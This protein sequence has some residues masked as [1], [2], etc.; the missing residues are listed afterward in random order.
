LGVAGWKTTEHE[1]DWHIWWTD[2]SVGEERCMRLRRPQ[3]LNHFPGMSE[4]A[5]KCKLARNLN[6]LRSVLP[7]LYNFH[8]E[9]FNLPVDYLAFENAALGDMEQRKGKGGKSNKS[10]IIKPDEGACGVGIFITRKPAEVPPKLACVAQRYLNKPLLIDDRKFDMRL[11]VLITSMTP[12][13]VYLFPEGLARFATE[14]FQPVTSANMNQRYM[15]L[16]NYSVNR[17]HKDFET[18]DSADAATGSKRS[19]TFVR[20]WLA[21]KGFD[22]KGIWTEIEKVIVKTLLAVQ[23]YVSHTYRTC[24]SSN[25]DCVGFSCFDLLGFDILLD[26]KAKPWIIEVNEMPSFETAAA[27]DLSTKAA[28]LHETLRLVCPTVQELRMLTEMTK[29]VK[30]A[31]EAKTAERRK[32]QALTPPPGGCGTGGGHS[33]QEQASRSAASDLSVENEIRQ[34]LLNLRVQQEK[35]QRTRFRLLY[36]LADPEEDGRCGGDEWCATADAL[37]KRY[38]EEPDD[39]ELGMSEEL[40]HFANASVPAARVRDAELMAEY[41]RCAAAS[42]EIFENNLWLRLGKVPCQTGRQRPG[43]PPNMVQAGQGALLSSIRQQQQKTTQRKPSV[44]EHHSQPGCI[45]PLQS[46]HRFSSPTSALSMSPGSS[47]VQSKE[48]SPKCHVNPQYEFVMGGGGAVRVVGVEQNHTRSRGDGEDS[49]SARRRCSASENGSKTRA[50]WEGGAES[51]ASSG[52]GPDGPGLEG[53]ESTG[54]G[55]EGNIPML[56][57]LALLRREH[58]EKRAANCRDVALTIGAPVGPQR[59]QILGSTSTGGGF[60]NW[61][62]RGDI[63]TDSAQCHVL[64]SKPNE[65]SMSGLANR[66]A[67]IGGRN[68]P[69]RSQ[70]NAHTLTDDHFTG[71]LGLDSEEDA[72]EGLR[73]ATSVRPISGRGVSAVTA[74]FSREGMRSIGRLG[75]A[76]SDRST[77]AVASA[78]GMAMSRNGAAQTLD[79][80][81]REVK[82]LTASMYGPAAASRGVIGQ[83]SA[84]CTGRLAQGLLQVLEPGGRQPTEVSLQGVRT[85]AVGRSAPPSSSAPSNTSFLAAT[86]MAGGRE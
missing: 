7:D 67:S 82:G 41:E 8:P 27:I 20:S 76:G 25:N 63:G 12:L 56:Q 86:R 84:L 22:V 51:D 62:K 39:V 35:Y 37:P 48:D 64:C 81:R 9:T 14:K 19:L 34:E 57:R 75:S 4:I 18:D 2:M 32:A 3:K 42:V 36:P 52:A 28:V 23:P 11:Y 38:A 10:Y 1:T 24:I 65:L 78:R 13:R 79:S 46:P 50:D 66:S 85:T 47:R 17:N 31:K 72:E 60:R 45:H 69:P 59:R 43:V 6:R 29:T 40:W 49:V 33:G 55:Y 16:T 54:A 68:D 77:G 83:H 5:H 15:H 61:A 73:R 74:P 58:D 80:A 70:S 21:D 53:V 71:S 44:G 30:M 26:H